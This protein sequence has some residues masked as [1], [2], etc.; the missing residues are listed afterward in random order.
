ML[1]INHIL[2]VLDSDHPEQIALDKAM[3]LA[4]QVN[5][6]I[7]LITSVYE[8]YCGEGSALDPDTK[9]RIHDARMESTEKW[10]N[11]FVPEVLSEGR[12]VATR[13]YWQKHLHDAVVEAMRQDH[14]DLVIKG[15]LPHSLID[16]IFTHTDWNLLRHC[17]APV[18]LVKS[19]TPWQ[20]NRL[21][22]SID[23]TSV[24]DGHQQINDNILAFAEHLADHFET[25]L[26]L[27]N[28]YPQISV[29]FAMVPE[30][31]APD[32]IQEYIVEQH[33]TACDQWARK[34]KVSE[35][36][37][38]I[39]EGETDEVVSAVATEI[40]ADLLVV[41]TMGRSGLAG[42]LIG[43]TAEQLVDKVPCDVLVVKPQDGV[44]E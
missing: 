43:N 15:T 1:D 6:D 16:R 25:D 13:V 23:A 31:T 3:W 8:P 44:A 2:V 18:L 26:H 4:G 9:K 33:K 35:D 39:G 37:V 41:G 42:V 36:H 28:A 11:S 22:A 34:Y 12:K 10:I 30:V 19:A 21:L 7:T 17:P 40:G 24:D 20:H 38:H 27:T 14:Y 32:D 5:A 29:A